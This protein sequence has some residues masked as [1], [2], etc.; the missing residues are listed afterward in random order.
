MDRR[1]GKRDDKRGRPAIGLRPSRG[2]ARSPAADP[3]LEARMPALRS[4]ARGLLGLGASS[5][6]LSGAETRRVGKAVARLRDGL[7]GSRGLSGG[8]YMDDPELLAA[9][10]LFY[11][12]VSYAQASRAFAVAGRRC[13]ASAI[14]RSPALDLGSGPGPMAARLLDMGASSATL[15]D[16]SPTALSVAKRLLG[17]GRAAT[18]QSRLEG[19]EPAAIGSGFSTLVLGNAFNELW[20]G[21]AERVALRRDFVLSLLPVLTPGAPVLMVEPALQGP[22][23]DAMALRDA[24]ADSGF[25]VVSPCPGDGPCPALSPGGGQSC[26][27]LWDWARPAGH[28]ALGAEAGIGKEELKASWFLFMAPGGQGPEPLPEGAGRVVSEGML[29][30]AGRLRY[31]LCGRDGLSSLSA[32]AADRPVLDPAFFSLGR[33]ALVRTQGAEAREGGLGLLPGSILDFPEA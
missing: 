24:L 31:R 12:P 18:V 10:L 21:K 7:T 26:H 14:A 8:P 11:W 16:G 30:K 22:C 17:G 23:R 25:R 6:P 5:E 3:L 19:L 32:R 15:V 13:P 4:E 2:E 27:D 33:Y 28:E 1:T 20:Q 29:N 9:Y